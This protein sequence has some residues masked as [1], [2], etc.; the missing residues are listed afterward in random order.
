[1]DRIRYV[2]ADDHQLFLK[3]FILLLQRI[4]SRYSLECVGEARNAQELLRLILPSEID[5][6]FLDLNFAETDA[7]LLIP[8]LKEMHGNLRILCVSM[9]TDDK[10]VRET[11][12]KGADGYL[13]KSTDPVDLALA[14]ES[15]ME[16]QM[17]LGKDIKITDPDKKPIHQ[18]T[19][20]NRFNAKYQLTKREKEILELIAKGKSNK[21]I[22]SMLFI[23]KDTVSVHRKNL[24]KKLNVRN[25]SGLIKVAFDFNLIN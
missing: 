13:S 25:A 6:L 14:I 24:M 5:L 22:A 1:M 9:Y 19:N 12:R 16:G 15:V 17:F 8:K 11:L 10:V 4:K 18:A 23:S 20:L 21:D 3:G 7:S 2:V